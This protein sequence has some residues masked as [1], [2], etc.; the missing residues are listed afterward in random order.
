MYKEL[1]QSFPGVS[2]FAIISLIIFFAMFAG[3]CYWAFFRAD[4]KYLKKMSNLPL[5]VSNSSTMNGE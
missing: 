2:I 1:L 5:N 4:K 3:V